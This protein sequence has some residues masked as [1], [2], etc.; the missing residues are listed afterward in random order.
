MRWALTKDGASRGWAP[1]DYCVYSLCTRASLKT[2]H[3]T[4]CTKTWTVHSLYTNAANLANLA[5]LYT[6]EISK[7]RRTCVAERYE[8][9]K[10]NNVK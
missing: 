7:L 5:N 9:W 10:E 4:I 3:S 6:R 8:E 2:S 1:S